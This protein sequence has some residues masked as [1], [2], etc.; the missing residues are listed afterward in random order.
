MS[1]GRNNRWGYTYFRVRE[2]VPLNFNKDYLTYIA[3]LRKTK[4]LHCPQL[5][6]PR[7]WWIRKGHKTWRTTQTTMRRYKCSIRESVHTSWYFN[8]LYM[9]PHLYTTSNVEFCWFYNFIFIFNLITCIRTTSWSTDVQQIPSLHQI[10]Y[11]QRIRYIK[12]YSSK[13]L[14]V[15]LTWRWPVG[16]QTCSEW[17]RK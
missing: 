10:A 11:V 4:S 5:G 3:G 8:I 16:A 17:E 9:G 15:Y 12:K 14:I 13:Y 2:T 6:S 1:E 7:R